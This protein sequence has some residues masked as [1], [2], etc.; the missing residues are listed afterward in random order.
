MRMN[1]V[2]R[3]SLRQQISPSSEYIVMIVRLIDCIQGAGMR[4]LDLTTILT[5]TRCRLFQAQGHFLLRCSIG[6][7]RIL[8]RSKGR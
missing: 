4:V 3:L 7:R 5:G 8:I 2:P 6:C 1:L